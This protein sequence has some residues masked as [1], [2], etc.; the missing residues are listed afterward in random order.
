MAHTSTN[1]FAQDGKAR[2]RDIISFWRAV[3]TLVP[4]RL[5][6]IPWP[7]GW[8]HAKARLPP[9][10]ILPNLIGTGCTDIGQSLELPLDRH[11][12]GK[13][14]FQTYVA[15]PVP[16]FNSRYAPATTLQTQFGIHQ[17]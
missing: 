4:T 16:C 9:L 3:Q 17:G 6:Q 12:P 11:R 8:I 2:N 10:S 15:R 13:P 5:V 7:G 1:R 14:T